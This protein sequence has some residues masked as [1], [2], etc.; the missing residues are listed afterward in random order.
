MNIFYYFIHKNLI[1][2]VGQK[3]KN[4]FRL[5]IAFSYSSSTASPLIADADET[6][7]S[8]PPY[9]SW[10]LVGVGDEGARRGRLMNF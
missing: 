9:V 5:L 6:I 10:D 4:V 2:L 1:W 8:D 3:S 7:Y